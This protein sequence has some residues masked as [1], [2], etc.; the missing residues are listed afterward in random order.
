[1]RSHN[2]KWHA[3]IN[4][5]I[6]FETG[7]FNNPRAVLFLGLYRNFDRLRPCSKTLESMTSS[8]GE[9]VL[10]QSAYLFTFSNYQSE[11]AKDNRKCR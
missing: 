10:S 7:R 9:N 6:L 11:Y 8:K 2:G 3:V 4:Y 1:M 5:T